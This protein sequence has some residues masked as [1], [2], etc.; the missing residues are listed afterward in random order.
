M[1]QDY[2]PESEFVDDE[3]QAD[4]SGFA[5]ESFD[6]P[7]SIDEKDFR[8]FWSNQSWWQVILGFFWQSPSNR[9]RDRYQ[10]MNRLNVSI[11]L[12]PYSPTNYVLR[13][14]LFIE[15]K[16][17]HL[18]QADFERALELA[19]DYEPESGWGLLEQAMQDRAI[20]GIKQAQRRLT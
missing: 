15:R 16:E 20:Q 10:R 4:D 18:A 6:E 1:T 2:L 17:Y 11:E 3:T 13:G 7:S 8:R 12:E 5:T 14:E 19:G 9:E